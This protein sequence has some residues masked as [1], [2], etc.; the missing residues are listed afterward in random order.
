MLRQVKNKVL[1]DYA[2]LI[3]KLINDITKITNKDC[4]MFIKNK[5]KRDRREKIGHERL[6][7]CLFVHT[8]T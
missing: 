4:L 1:R 3:F 2:F 8:E 5:G 7:G 6:K